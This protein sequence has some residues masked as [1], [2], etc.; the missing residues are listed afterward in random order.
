MQNL[1][2]PS[3]TASVP[4]RYKRTAIEEVISAFE[5]RESSRRSSYFGSPEEAVTKQ[6]QGS[7]PAT[8]SSGSVSFSS[9]ELFDS[10]QN[11]SSQDISMMR[12]WSSSPP[13]FPPQR[14][15]S[16]KPEEE[17]Q[18]DQIRPPA[19]QPGFTG[20]DGGPCT[21]PFDPFSGWRT[22][23]ENSSYQE[24]EETRTSIY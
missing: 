20:W 7:K 10:S 12:E 21:P 17:T 14:R 4:F 5:L 16:P 15:R 19:R 24:W 6:T 2:S 1:W 3:V 8:L 9:E 18:R 11:I 23:P 22:S 13:P